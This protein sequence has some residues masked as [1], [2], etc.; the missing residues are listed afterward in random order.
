[1]RSSTYHRALELDLV[2]PPVYLRQMGGVLVEN[3]LQ[4][5]QIISGMRLMRKYAYS[6]KGVRIMDITGRKYVSLFLLITGTMAWRYF[7][8]NLNVLIQPRSDRFSY[9]L[10][11]QQREIVLDR[12]R[13]SELFS[14]RRCRILPAWEIW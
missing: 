12:R 11:N 13:C 4:V 6:K 5:F 8:L 3:K 14:W 7:F 1:M 2:L 9:V 10:P